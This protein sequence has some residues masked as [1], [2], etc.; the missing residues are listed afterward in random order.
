MSMSISRMNLNLLF[1]AAASIVV[2]SSVPVWAQEPAA[3]ESVAETEEAIAE[4][5]GECR[6]FYLTRMREEQ[7]GVTSAAGLGREFPRPEGL[8]ESTLNDLD[9]FESALIIF[10]QEIGNYRATIG[11]IVESEYRERRSS[12]GDF[13][14]SAIDGLR[15]EE[16]ARR[17]E[18]IANFQRFLDRYPDDATY[19]PDVM[20]R[21]AELYYED[22]IEQYRAQDRNYLSLMA[23]YD[24]GILPEPP[25]V[26]EY[27]FTR[28]M[29]L[30]DDLIRRFPDYRQIDG[31]YYLDGVCHLQMGM[32]DDAQVYFSTLVRDYPQSDFAQEV[33]LR[34]GEYHFS[35]YEFELARAAYQR[36]VSYGDSRWYDEALFKLGW[37]NYLLTEY[38][39]AI[40]SFRAVLD[41]YEEQV[42]GSVAVREESL[43]YFAISIAEDDWDGDYEPDFD[44]IIPR[45]ERVILSEDR[46]YNIEILD[47]LAELLLRANR[48]DYSAQIY[49]RVL[50]DHPLD[51]RNPE[52]HFQLIAALVSNGQDDQ[53]VRELAT[54]AMSYSPDSPWYREQ[55]RLGNAEALAYAD[56][57]AR[58][59]LLDS[60]DNAYVSAQALA[61]QAAQTGDSIIEEDAKAQ[62]RVAATLYAEFLEQYPDADEAFDARISFAQAL[63]FS[64]QF[65]ASAE[66][67]ERIRDMA[68][69]EDGQLIGATQAILAWG[70][71][72]EQEINDG[73][74]ETRAYPQYTGPMLA[75]VDEDLD[76]DLD[77]EDDEPQRSGPRE[78]PANELIPELSLSWAA[79]NDRFIELG[80]DDPDME[81]RD[82]LAL[83]DTAYLYYKYKHYDTA[84]ERFISVIDECRPIDATGYAAALLIESFTVTNDLEALTFW[85][86][87]LE[88]RAECVPEELRNRVL[89]DVDRMAMGEMAR[90]A[91]ELVA[92]SRFEEAAE[93]YIRLAAEYADNPDTASRA[94]F[95]AGVIYETNLSRYADAMNAFDRIVNEY[96]ETEFLDDALVRIAVNSKKFFDFERAI[97][98][99]QT[100]DSMN[101]SSDA[102]PSPLLSAAELLQQS[103]R[104]VEAAESFLEYVD[105][106]P[107]DERAPEWVYRAALN[108]R[109][110]GQYDD[111]LSVFDDFR[112]RY[113]NAYGSASFSVDAAIIESYDI[114]ATYYEEQG[115]TRNMQR[116]RDSVMREFAARQ[117]TNPA[118]RSAA[119]EIAYEDAMAQYN[120]WAD[121]EVASDFD[122]RV[123]IMRDK[124]ENMAD[125]AI[126]FD[127]IGDYEVMDWTVCGLYM[128]GRVFQ[129]YSEMVRPLTLPP[130]GLTVEEEDEYYYALGDIIMQIEDAMLRPAEDEAVNRWRIAYEVMQGGGVVN[131]C[132]IDTIRQLHRVDPEGVPLFKE[133]VRHVEPTTFS[134]A[135]FAVP[136]LPTRPDEDAPSVVMPGNDD[137]ETEEF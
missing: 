129:T 81:H 33:W 119:A 58:T 72:L 8:E 104:H 36:S 43:Q 29:S 79:A 137:S 40:D 116:A 100:L 59:S 47:R 14:D 98:T 84:R 120:E 121:F 28:T 42:S 12:I 77:E 37:S 39:L 23:R 75:A 106:N 105:N 133:G 26:P 10:E 127:E 5:E 117:P 88:R 18:A 68:D 87:E 96:G 82:V 63:L 107:R 38:E 80:I 112:R 93:E 83:Y 92:E 136:P 118:A 45:V 65:V 66:Q 113:R 73:R 64:G 110:A 30:F 52:R 94:L 97:A 71:A 34:I 7:A 114:A 27:D 128:T 124:Q 21:L 126:M 31:A 109:D 108:Y 46:P 16:S 123:E 76:A 3:E 17:V 11:R 62:F 20:F 13:F 55:E 95:N 111:M 60:A 6:D 70:L 61:D 135:T 78:A 24:A 1:A 74:L 48:F 50:A 86:Q 15:A 56:D 99:Y 122:D 69:E 9:A 54:I 91:D 89:A 53:A 90:R 103:G 130:E 32:D 19:T 102:V 44:Y 41:Y 131:D 125:I 134:P 101:Y 25:D 132:T 67:Y 51:R 115:Q 22:S 85:S 49:R 57:L 4:E 2:F 35:V